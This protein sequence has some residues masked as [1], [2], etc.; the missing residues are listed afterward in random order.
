MA[1]S[2]ATPVSFT[3]MS[4]RKEPRLDSCLVHVKVSFFFIF[5]FALHEVMGWYSKC[6]PTRL[7]STPVTNKSSWI[8]LSPKWSQTTYCSNSWV[9]TIC[10][11]SSQCYQKTTCRV[12]MQSFWENLLFSECH[13]N[14]QVYKFAEVKRGE[15]P[16]E[17]WS[18]PYNVHE[19]IKGPRN[20]HNSH[21]VDMIYYVWFVFCLLVLVSMVNGSVLWNQTAGRD[22][23][24]V[25]HLGT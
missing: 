12:K 1:N 4:A 21:H 17:K 2:T 25:P 18:V 3:D 6:Q 10:H 16:C 14:G 19:G 23:R 9:Q 13:Y 20:G 7:H 24:P 11:V 22:S 5:F 15:D 8:L